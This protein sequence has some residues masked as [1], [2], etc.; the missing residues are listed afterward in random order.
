[1]A[2]IND[3]LLLKKIAG[4]HR[5]GCRRRTCII[6]YMVAEIDLVNLY[7]T[8]HPHP[9]KQGVGR[10]HRNK[11]AKIKEILRLKWK[12]QLCGWLYTAATKYH[13]DI[14]RNISNGLQ[15]QV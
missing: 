3:Q 10:Y 12:C 7:I 14:W 4:N 11:C 6:Y 2:F 13:K 9:S 15:R 5:D 8:R 1:M